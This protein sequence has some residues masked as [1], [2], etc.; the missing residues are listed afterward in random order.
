MSTPRAV[1]ISDVH[2]NLQNLECADKV[3]R[4]A[5]EKAC[6][7]Q[8]PCIVAGDLHDTKALMRSECV[9]A[10]IQ[11]FAHGPYKNSLESSKVYII[12]GNHCRENEKSENHSLRF[13]E[14]YVH[15]ISDPVYVNDLGWWFIPYQHDSEFLKKI[16]KNIPTGATV[17]AHQG[18]EGAF[19]GHYTQD[20]TSLPKSE[21]S[22]FRTI[23]GHYH[24]RQDIRCGKKGLFSYLGSPYTMNFGEAL[25]GPKGFSILKNDGSLELVETHLRRHV[26]I[27]TEASNWKN[28]KIFTRSDDIIW[29]KVRGSV[30]ELSLLKKSE[31]AEFLGTKNFKFDKISTEVKK[32]ETNENISDFE[33]LIKL[34]ESTFE[35]KEKQ[36]RL[37]KLAKEL[38][39]ETDS[40]TS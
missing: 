17:I 34:I 1:F 13:L 11:T 30:S 27:E 4:M 33:I 23:S 25:D 6:E 22:R 32:I 26:V 9:N 35:S 14:P 31:I 18:V 2:Y 5:L 36:S 20:K 29:F 7:L 40:S 12:P 37:K 15:V 8:I 39:N 10:M 28:L 24:K 21:W 3:M 19:M 38:L 16:L